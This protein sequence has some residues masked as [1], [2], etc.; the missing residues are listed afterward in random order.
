[1]LDKAVDVSKL[2]ESP[3]PSSLS[4]E[5]QMVPKSLPPIL[6]E[7]LEQE[8]ELEKAPLLPVEDVIVGN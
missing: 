7:L 6:E 1:M 2:G 4:V 5:P 8:P 3:R